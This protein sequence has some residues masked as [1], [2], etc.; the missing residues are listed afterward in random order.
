[1]KFETRR[2]VWI[3]ARAIAAGWAALVV[4]AYLIERPLLRWTAPM[5]EG[6]WVPTA[7]L[8][9]DCCAFAA[10]GWVIGYFSRDDSVIALLAFAV[11]LTWRDFTPLLPVNVPWLLR[12]VV[13]T[14]T[15]SRYFA[16]FVSTAA[17]HAILFG[18]LFAGGLLTRRA[19]RSPSVVPNSQTGARRDR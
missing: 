9:L 4:I 6:S 14:F 3:C 15:D 11:T 1:V 17:T 8:A 16:G 18:S 12:S 2:R 5:L 19:Q 13:N 10:T 7:E